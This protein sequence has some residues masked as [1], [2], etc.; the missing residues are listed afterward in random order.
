MLY[1]IYARLAHNDMYH[2]IY[3][4]VPIFQIDEPKVIAYND[5]KGEVQYV[6]MFSDV[7][8]QYYGA[9]RNVYSEA[10][11]K[12]LANKLVW[13]NDYSQITLIGFPHEQSYECVYRNPYCKFK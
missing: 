10:Q 11:L 7:A 5:F 8:N 4:C 1:A 12:I 3:S 2:I 9:F 6:H 13:D